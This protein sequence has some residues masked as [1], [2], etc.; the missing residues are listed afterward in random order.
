MS[1]I[2]RIKHSI[3][4]FEIMTTKENNSISKLNKNDLEQLYKHLRNKF[5]KLLKYV[6]ETGQNI[7]YLCEDGVDTNFYYC[8]NDNEDDNVY[9]FDFN[10]DK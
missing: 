9:S 2:S 3:S 1:N 6:K 10:D 7:E 8:N 4:Q 5:D